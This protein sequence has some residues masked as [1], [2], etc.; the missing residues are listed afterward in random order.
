MLEV[1]CD[2]FVGGVAEGG[3]GADGEGVL[4]GDEFLNEVVFGVFT[5][6]VSGDDAGEGSFRGDD[7]VGVED[8]VFGVD[9]L[10]GGGEGFFG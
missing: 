3:V 7:G 1:V 2:H 4:V 9:P 5:E 8:G 10:E 6:L